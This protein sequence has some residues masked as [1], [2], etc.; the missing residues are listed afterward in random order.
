M[1]GEWEPPLM[2]NPKC[3]DAPGCGPW[4]APNKVNEKYKGKW[5]PPMIDNPDYKGKW[6]PKK[7]SNP[8]YFYDEKPFRS[9]PIVSEL[10][11]LNILQPNVRLLIR[12][13]LKFIISD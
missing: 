12:L 13:V 10:M 7:I 4:T 9:S 11:A 3:K 8:D 5:K 1:D 6:T 2:E